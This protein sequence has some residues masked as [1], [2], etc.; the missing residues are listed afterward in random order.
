MR[1]GEEDVERWERKGR[2]VDEPLYLVWEDSSKTYMKDNGRGE[3][4][5]SETRE[6]KLKQGAGEDKMEGFWSMAEKD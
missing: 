1:M 4:C 6:N 5:M 2:E 3:Q